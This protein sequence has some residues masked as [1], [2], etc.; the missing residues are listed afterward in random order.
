MRVLTL[1]QGTDEWYAARKGRITSSGIDRCLAGKNTKGRAQYAQQIVLDLENVEDFRD[2]APWFLAG[3]KYESYARGW[4]QWEHKN[5]DEVG[6]VLH[7]KYNWLGASPDGLIGTDGNL[8]IKYR[9]SLHTFHQ[10]IV[11]P[12]PRAYLYQMQLQMF[13]C[14]RQ[15][16]AYVNYWRNEAKAQEQGHVT[17]IERDDAL[18]RELEEAAMLFWRDD[19]VPLWRARNAE[20]PIA[21]PWDE[22]CEKRNRPKEIQHGNEG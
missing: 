15:W 1:T 8:E 22:Y 6:F 11:K 10:A 7:D 2:D 20:K 16:T 17:I 21:F 19:V 18:I 4:Y 9:K 5:V 13:V 12:P 3:R 14:D